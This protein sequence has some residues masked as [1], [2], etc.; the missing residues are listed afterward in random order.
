[1]SLFL[2]AIE[3]LLCLSSASLR[4]QYVI[5]FISMFSPLHCVSKSTRNG[6]LFRKSQGKKI[7]FIFVCCFFEIWKKKK[8]SSFSVACL[9]FFYLNLDSFTL[10]FSLFI[11][12]YSK[13]II[14]TCASFR[15]NRYLPLAATL[16]SHRSLAHYTREVTLFKKKKKTI[17]KSFYLLE[18]CS[19]A[20]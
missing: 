8:N 18:S 1:M 7:I 20:K 19:S 3:C 4:V 10:P 6:S 2:R 13:S 9:S 17:E 11:P 5:D 12:L 14:I 15:H 16:A